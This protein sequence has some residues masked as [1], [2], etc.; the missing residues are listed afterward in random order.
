MEVKKNRE[1]QQMMIEYGK[2]LKKDIDQ[3]NCIKIREKTMK[4]NEYSDFVKS[5][6]LR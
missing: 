3:R 2:E 4:K 6:D 5:E 1:R